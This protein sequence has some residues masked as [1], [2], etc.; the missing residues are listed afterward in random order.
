MFMKLAALFSGGKDSMYA[1]YRMLQQGHDV[2]YL[3]TFKPQR[4]DSYMF[5]HP[6]VEL[7]ELQAEAI[8]IKQIMVSTSGVKEKELEDLENVLEK[9]KGEIDGIVSGALA[10]NYQKT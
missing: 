1:L 10:S 6:C 8:G 5:H 7:T 4:T 2:K 3:V 9:I